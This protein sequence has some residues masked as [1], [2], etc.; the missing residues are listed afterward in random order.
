M[1]AAVMWNMAGPGSGGPGEI[2]LS[3]EEDSDCTSERAIYP[4]EESSDAFS[5]MTTKNAPAGEVS[6]TTDNEDH[7]ART[8]LCA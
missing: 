1:K 6:T 5:I 7:L 2:F 4:S 3:D 8:S